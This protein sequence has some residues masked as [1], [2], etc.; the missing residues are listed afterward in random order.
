MLLGSNI[1]SKSMLGNDMLKEG[2]VFM[3]TFHPVG[4]SS[5]SKLKDIECLHVIFLITNIGY[6]DIKRK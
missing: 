5:V 3:K 1:A 2:N 6:G 4:E